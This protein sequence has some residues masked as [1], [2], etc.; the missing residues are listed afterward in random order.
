MLQI[1][2]SNHFDLCLMARR[3]NQANIARNQSGPEFLGK[4]NVGRVIRGE[5]MTK[6]PDAGKQNE[7]WIAR[8]AHILQ[9]VE[10]FF[11]TRSRE[12]TF[13]YETPQD[14]RDFQIQQVRR[15][16]RFAAREDSR[17]DLLSRRRLK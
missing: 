5:V 10:R 8:K 1:A 17:L 15:M 6:P 3:G 7:V 11:G 12:R 9:V 2:A 4:Y 13:P 16:Q 14:L